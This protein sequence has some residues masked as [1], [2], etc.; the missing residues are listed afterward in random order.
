MN[1]HIGVLSVVNSAQT[2]R[3]IFRVRRVAMTAI[4]RTRPEGLIISLSSLS[5][6]LE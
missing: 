3:D 5:D 1:D 4:R 6:L 2:Q